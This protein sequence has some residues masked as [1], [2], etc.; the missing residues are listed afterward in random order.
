M[1]PELHRII[2]QD[3]AEVVMREETDTIPVIDDIRSHIRASV[4]T[5]SDMEEAEARMSIVD[6][7]LAQL[8]L[9]A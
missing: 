5:M 4:K 6:S 2:E 1:D 9:A 8:G 7:L 3:A